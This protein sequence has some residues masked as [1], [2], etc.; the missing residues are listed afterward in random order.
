MLCEQYSPTGRMEIGV[1]ELMRTE[2]KTANQGASEKRKIANPW[3]G[4]ESYAAWG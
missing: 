2:T 3:Q 1:G 4:A